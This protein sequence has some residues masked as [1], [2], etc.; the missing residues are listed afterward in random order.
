[1]LCVT[2]AQHLKITFHFFATYTGN[3]HLDSLKKKKVWGRLFGKSEKKLHSAK[4]VHLFQST[5]SYMQ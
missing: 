3:M 2:S 1:M 5:N 4:A